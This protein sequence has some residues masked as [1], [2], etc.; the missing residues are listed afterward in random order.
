M[1]KS[2]IFSSNKLWDK[3]TQTKVQSDNH[4]VV[5]Y[6]TALFLI[7]IEPIAIE[8]VEQFIEVFFMLKS[9]LAS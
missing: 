2:F 1:I 5:D 4:P 3:R 6:S 9:F 8:K 7:G